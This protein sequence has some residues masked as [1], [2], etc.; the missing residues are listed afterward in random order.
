MD[1]EELQEEVKKMKSDQEQFKYDSVEFHLQQVR[2]LALRPSTPNEVMLATVETLYDTANA[3]KHPDT[4]TY[5]IALKACRENVNSGK[6]HGL[7]T[8]LL[9]TDAAKKAQ[10]AI[11]AWKKAERKKEKQEG[12]D[13]DTPSTNVNNT[14]AN[15]MNNVPNQM[16]GFGQAPPPWWFG[17]F[18][19]TGY[20]SFQRPS[21]YRGRGRGGRTNNRQ[22][23]ICRSSDHMVSSCPYNSL[24]DKP[25]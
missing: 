8:K 13:K 18:G 23:F 2:T 20:Q 25:Q 7:V 16:Q 11:E 15:S 12:K 1:F 9:G 21:F 3:L 22:C 5:K 4:D 6:L 14:A 19:A 17:N 10:S 24:K